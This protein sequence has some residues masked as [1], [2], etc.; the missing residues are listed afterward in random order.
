MVGKAASFSL[1]ESFHPQR[2]HIF[3]LT[4][5]VLIMLTWQVDR[6]LAERGAILESLGELQE[7]YKAQTAANTATVR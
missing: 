4:N 3:L 7:A 6:M 5:H 2:T 1:V